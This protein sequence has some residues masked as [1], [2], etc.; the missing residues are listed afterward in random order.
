MDRILDFLKLKHV[1]QN[2]VNCGLTDLIVSL[3]FVQIYSMTK[4]RC[5]IVLTRLSV[6]VCILFIYTPVTQLQS[7]TSFLVWQMCKYCISA[8]L[9][10]HY[11]EPDTD[12]HLT[13]MW[14]Q[15]VCDVD[16]L[17]LLVWNVSQRVSGT[18]W[19]PKKNMPARA[20][21]ISSNLLWHKVCYF[22]FIQEVFM[23]M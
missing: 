12:V 4:S 14:N 17:S 5:H 20:S 10:H 8:W 7:L 11:E 21:I 23:T 19:H 2:T 15:A 3:Q 1:E 6:C 13:L 16:I 18:F 22:Q 9:I